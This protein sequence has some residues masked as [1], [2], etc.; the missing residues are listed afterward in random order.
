MYTE[1][2]ASF[3]IMFFILSLSESKFF[4]MSKS[5]LYMITGFI[6]LFIFIFINIIL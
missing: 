3:A 6:F 2:Y 5:E 4:P 1:I